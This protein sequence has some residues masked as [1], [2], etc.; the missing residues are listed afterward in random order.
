MAAPPIPTGESAVDVKN[1]SIGEF[2]ASEE[3]VMMPPHGDDVTASAARGDRRRRRLVG[4]SRSKTIVST[5]QVHGRKD[6]PA[7]GSISPHPQRRRSEDDEVAS[8]ALPGEMLICPH[9][10]DGSRRDVDL[11]SLVPTAGGFA[12]STLAYSLTPITHALSTHSPPPRATAPPPA[13]VAPPTPPLS[14]TKPG[15]LSPITGG[16]HRRLE[17]ALAAQPRGDGVGVEVRRARLGLRQVLHVVVEVLELGIVRADR[18]GVE[19]G[20]AQVVGGEMVVEGEPEGEPPQPVGLFHGAIA[21][22]FE[23][24]VALRRLR[25]M[26]GPTRSARAGR[27]PAVPV[28]TTG[29]ARARRRVVNRVLTWPA[30]WNPATTAASPNVAHLPPRLVPTCRRTRG[31]RPRGSRREGGGDGVGVLV[32]ASRRAR[33]GSRCRTARSTRCA[34]RRVSRRR[35]GACTRARKKSSGSPRLSGRAGRARRSARARRHLHERRLEERV[36]NRHCAS[37]AVRRAPT[38]RRVAR[39]PVDRREARQAVDDASASRR[40]WARADVAF[41]VAQPRRCSCLQGSGHQWRAL[42]K[43]HLQSGCEDEGSLRKTRLRA[44]RNRMAK[45][46]PT[47]LPAA[48]FLHVHTSSVEETVA[49]DRAP[50]LAFVSLLFFWFTCYRMRA[51]LLLPTCAIRRSGRRRRRPPRLRHVLRICMTERLAALIANPGARFTGSPVCGECFDAF[52]HD[53]QTATDGPMAVIRARADG[54]TGPCLHALLVLA[55]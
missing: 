22:P 32:A 46:Q 16:R 53:T 19:R 5:L 43:A 55:Q 23:R 31:G 30:P 42:G 14:H 51:V 13:S 12:C 37:H 49:T 25:C 52:V 54:A 4:G 24:Q 10:T 41:A 20:G 27:R 45:E 7:H 15:G 11:P 6:A 47:R 39:R 44:R 28:P 3:S 35:S 21:R 38:R 18:R 1:G 34:A 33:S 50:H 9:G 36:D 2:S 8:F 40:Q 29:S 48:E 26:C 17:A